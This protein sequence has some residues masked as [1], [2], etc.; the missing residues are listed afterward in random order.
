M[1]TM[2][3]SRLV[4]RELADDDFDACQELLTEDF[5]YYGGPYEEDLDLRRRFD[6]LVSLTNWKSA[7]HLY[8]DHAIVLKQSNELIGMCGIDPWVWKTE[9]K[10]ML[11]ELFPEARGGKPC[12][13]IEFE[14]GYALKKD[15]RGNGY[16]TEAVLRLIDSAFE[17]AGIAAI[18]ARTSDGNRRSIRMMERI[19]MQIQSSKAW[20]GCAGSIRNPDG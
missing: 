18:Y 20:G 6:W 14:L 3:S 12:T 15:V 10:R 1:K 2:E 9:T 19:G 5:D 17:D 4:I 8:G 11:P 7:G 13:T 16:A